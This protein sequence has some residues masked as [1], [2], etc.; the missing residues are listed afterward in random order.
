MIIECSHHLDQANGYAD[1]LQHRD[2]DVSSTGIN[3]NFK[4]K[5]TKGSDNGTLN[6]DQF[7]EGLNTS[8]YAK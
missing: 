6:V 2:G 3:R 4:H 8:A 1:L 7:R 5:K